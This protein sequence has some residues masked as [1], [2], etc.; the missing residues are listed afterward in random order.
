MMRPAASDP[1]MLTRVAAP[2]DRSVTFAV[3]G[4]PLRSALARLF[5][6]T[7]LSYA[8]APDV[9]NPPITISMQDVPFGTALQTLTQVAGVTYRRENDVYVIGTRPS[10]SEPIVANAAPVAAR[11]VTLHLKEV[12]LRQALE[13]LFEGTGLQFA[14]APDVPNPPITIE[15]RDEEFATA[16]RQIVRL[17]AVAT[18]RKEGSIYIIG[19]RS[20]EATEPEQKIPLLGELPIVGRL[21]AAPGKPEGG[22]GEP[23]ERKVTLALKAVP[24]RQALEQIFRGSGLRC[25]VELGISNTPV[26]LNVRE[27][28]FSSVLGR[29]VDQV[30]ATYQRE[31]PFVVIGKPQRGAPAVP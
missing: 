13:Q 26:S 18:Y 11:R 3:Q 17:S 25:A 27:E 6:G 7:G 12:P 24:L 23:A 10:A 19:V 16:L 29:L 9:P 20:P 4:I 1:R 30:G 14:I 15:L 22:A 5:R 21:F 28:P 2:A 31:G 8:V